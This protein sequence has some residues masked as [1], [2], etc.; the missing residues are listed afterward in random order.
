MDSRGR[1]QIDGQIRRQIRTVVMEVS[2]AAG[3]LRDISE[4]LLSRSKA[5]SDIVRSTIFKVAAD[6]RFTSTAL[7]RLD[8]QKKAEDALIALA[9]E[10]STNVEKG[11]TSEESIQSV[12]DEFFVWWMSQMIETRAII[13]DSDPDIKELPNLPMTKV[14]KAMARR[15]DRVVKDG[16]GLPEIPDNTYPSNEKQDGLHENQDRLRD[17]FLQDAC[18][19]FFSPPKEFA[20]E[21]DRYSEGSSRMVYSGKTKG[22]EIELSFLKHIPSELYK[23]ARKIGRSSDDSS[24][25]QGSRF[26]T[27]SKSDIVGITSGNDLSA[28]LPSEI[29]TFSTPE[30]STLFY[31]N[32]AQKRLQTF[33]SASSSHDPHKHENGPIIICLDTSSSMNGEP[34]KVATAIT[35]AVSIIARRQKREVIIVKYS[36]SYEM[37]RVKDI[38]KERRDLRYFL[39]HVDASG[40]NENVMFRWLFND[41]LPDEKKDFKN[42]DLLCVSDFGWCLIAED[43]REQFAQLKKTGMRCYGL[44]I[45]PYLPGERVEFKNTMDVLDSVWTYWSGHCWESYSSVSS[46]R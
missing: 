3:S 28:L 22:Q 34:V 15:P 21:S 4:E 19:R 39:T 8:W 24:S 40:N 27:A 20:D 41:V 18:N 36:N 14:P 32:Y 5:S 44:N 31:R 11:E 17:E 26:M 45:G 43:V 42:T 1:Q 46:K 12:I 2:G 10:I 6:C 13:K 29:A 35:L 23:L 7:P 38:I 9:V 37:K 16:K 25:R 30:C 33:A